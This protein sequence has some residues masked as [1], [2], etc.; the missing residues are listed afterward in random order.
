GNST[1][2]TSPD[3]CSVIAASSRCFS[4]TGGGQRHPVTVII[5]F[6]LPPRIAP[7]PVT[8]ATFERDF[9]AIHPGNGA[10]SEES[11]LINGQPVEAL[12]LICHRDFAEKRSRIILKKLKEQ[13]DRHQFEIPLQAAIGGKIIAR[14]SIKAM[15]KN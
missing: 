3:S 13:I 8:F 1:L 4:L 7:P 6:I 5:I 2:F 10:Y 15:R 11:I 9:T 14:E 12:S